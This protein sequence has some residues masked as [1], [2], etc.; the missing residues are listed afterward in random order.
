MC[1]LFGTTGKKPHRWNEQ[2]QEFF[3]HSVAHK[4]GRGIATFDFGAPKRERG[5]EA[6]HESARVEELPANELE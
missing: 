4:D 1:E 6:A 2:L 3:S 5:T